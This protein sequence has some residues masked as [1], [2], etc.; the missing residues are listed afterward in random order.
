[1]MSSI[2]DSSASQ[3]TYW[4]TE[5]DVF[6]NWLTGPERRLFCP[7]IPG[8]GKSVLA[9]RVTG[10]LRSLVSSDETVNLA[11]VFCDY[12][13][14]DQLSTLN[15]LGAILRQLVQNRKSLAEPLLTLYEQH[16]ESQTLPS[17]GELISAILAI[18]KKH[19][20]VFIVV[21]A[22]DEIPIIKGRRQQLLK[23]FHRL[24]LESDTI[25]F[26]VTSRTSPD[27]VH[28][29]E[30]D[31]SFEVLA[32]PEDIERYVESRFDDFKAPLNE[33]FC[34]LVK[35]TIVDAANGM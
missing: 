7:G 25:R 28:E 19:E 29:F 20:H 27:I 35:S 9:A 15:I 5:S 3:P 6:K 18:A 12:K 13:A 32:M 10:H 24:H 1:M 31:P 4:F 2:W 22:L 8:A 11:F 26:L 23:A 30:G 21:D 16:V 33:D 17:P 34:K 14:A